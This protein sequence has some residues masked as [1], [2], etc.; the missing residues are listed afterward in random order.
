M[1]LYN[2]LTRKKSDFKAIK[3]KEVRMY[4]C[5]PTVYSHAHIGNLRAYIISDTLRRMFE[6]RS[7]KVIHVMNITDVGHLVGDGSLG[8]DKLKQ[9]ARIEHKSAKEIAKEYERLFLKDIKK[10]GI[11]MPSI[12]ARATDHIPQMLDLIERLERRGYLYKAETGIYFDTSKFKDYGNLSGTDF[13]RL[14]SSLIGGAR[15]ERPSGTR[16]ITDFAVWRFSP[17]KEKEMVWDSK[18]GRGFPGWHIEC[19]AISMEYLGNHFDVHTGGVDHIQIHHQ[20]EIAQS[21]GATGEKFVNF[22]VHNEFLKVNG[23]KMS[24]SLH[25]TYTIEDLEGMGIS[26]Q[27]YRYFVLT[28]HYRS[29]MNM[30]KEALGNAQRTIASIHSF[31]ERISGYD[32]E[33][34]PDREFIEEIASLER[35]FFEWM[36]DDMNTPEALASLH[37]LISVVNKCHSTGKL[38]KA[39]RDAVMATL[40]KMDSVLGLSFKEHTETKPLAAEPKRLIEEREK[41]RQSGDFKSADEIRQELKERFGII[42]EDGKNGSVWRRQ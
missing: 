23:S 39:G 41:A 19:S 1:K 16:N 24:K 3:E 40:L 33:G 4:S 6:H 25:N 14:N 12:I 35:E 9:T 11:K 21:E 34:K 8:E 18:Y 15:I 20:N 30:T 5:G 2:T 38:S 36:E 42:V 17:E 22:W 10:I 27:G 7:Y 37:A 29:I 32:A 26:P 28:G 13:K 31:I